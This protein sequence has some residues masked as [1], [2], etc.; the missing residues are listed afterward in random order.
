M[1]K[2]LTDNVNIDY[3]KYLEITALCKHIDKFFQDFLNME[4]DNDQDKEVVRVLRTYKDKSTS[5]DHESRKII[6]QHIRNILLKGFSIY[7]INDK[8]ELTGKIS[9]RGVSF[10]ENS[11]L[12]DF[13]MPFD[14]PIKLTAEEK[15]EIL[16]HKLAVI[17]PNERDGAFKQLIDKYKELY[18]KTRTTDDY[19]SI[20]FEI[21]KR[22]VHKMY[23]EENITLSFVDKLDIITQKLYE[24][25]FGLKALDILA[26]SDINEVGFANNGQYVYCWCNLKYYLSFITLSEPSARQIQDRA[27]SFD[28]SISSLNESNPEVLC[29]RADGA[30]ITVMQKPYFSARN[31]CIRIFNE[32]HLDFHS[33]L[34]D[35]KLR[36]LMT[37][38]VKAGECLALQGG[39]GTGKTTL[40]KV[41]FEV[42]DDYL[43][44][45]LAEEMFEQHIIDMYPRKRILEA[46]PVKGKSLEDVVATF[47]R[48]SVDVAGLGEGR[49]GAAIY[50]FI[51]L[52]QS[53]SIAAWFTAQ[54]N[55]PDNTI[56]RLKNMVMGT[57]HYTNEQAAVADLVNNIN[58]IVQHD[59]VDGRRMIT[60]VVEIVPLITTSFKHESI[61]LNTDLETLQRLYYIQQIQ[62]NTANMYK[63]NPIMEVIDNQVKFINYPT[64]RMIDKT[65]KYP[66]SRVYMDRLLK[67]IEED[68]GRPHSLNLWW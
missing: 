28:Q 62:N 38:L 61:D 3:A 14:E 21:D 47:L 7:E 50:S 17:S 55:S 10:S 66:G 5:G 56:P 42:L 13:V 60:Q 46:Q 64:Q 65:K 68:T 54:I 16:L 22:D 51:Q 8:D 48:S 29:H 15:F 39:L 34:K 36:L 6:K 1:N 40:M 25:I 53:V 49:S 30:R 18:R 45:G 57:G 19:E 35:D 26:Y 2:Q 67:A 59:I 44:I 12:I 31:C 11:S 41:L 52:V 20:G 43:H 63:L 58:C 23:M 37:A 27:I 24:D 32:S 4:P 33:L 9:L